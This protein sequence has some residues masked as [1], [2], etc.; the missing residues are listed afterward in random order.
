MKKRNSYH[1]SSVLMIFQI[2]LVLIVLISFIWAVYH[3]YRIIGTS[4]SI[5]MIV[6]VF[7]ASYF[8]FASL[9]GIY[10]IELDKR[11]ITLKKRFGKRKTIPFEELK[12][13][14]TTNSFLIKLFYVDNR[15][16][17][18]FKLEFFRK[19]DRKEI[20]ELI[21]NRIMEVNKERFWELNHDEL[22]NLFGDNQ[23]NFTK[24][25][26][27]FTHYLMLMLLFSLLPTVALIVIIL[28]LIFGEPKEIFS[29]I[30]EWTLIFFL[31][32]IIILI[33][34]KLLPKKSLELKNGILTLFKKN[35][36]SKKVNL[37]SISSYHINYKSVKWQ[38]TNRIF[39]ENVIEL[40][41]FS[42]QD[43]KEI[44]HKLKLFLRT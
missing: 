10:Q 27:H 17:T 35:R 15:K 1:I 21:Y 44:I 11:E 39:E 19:T 16:P 31:L 14:S 30:E 34:D 32:P 43:R 22:E 6:F 5:I 24:T 37:K 13:V 28:L 2:I 12:D 40:L 8:L 4:Y 23:Y 26:T 33:V 25:E 38:K 9:S 3:F 41:G 7:I 18:R 29:V 20:C 36:I 42:K